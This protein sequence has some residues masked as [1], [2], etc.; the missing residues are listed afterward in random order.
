[1]IGTICLFAMLNCK[2]AVTQRS[3][4]AL[5]SETTKVSLCGLVSETEWKSMKT[6]LKSV[7]SES[8]EICYY[9]DV[10]NTGPHPLTE[11]QSM[12]CFTTS[13]WFALLRCGWPVCFSGEK[14][15]TSTAGTS[16]AD[17]PPPVHTDPKK[18]PFPVFCQA[19]QAQKKLLCLQSQAH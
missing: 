11:L 3:K 14:E 4:S 9:S 5:H 10:C 13:H 15:L 12:R 6:W 18:K 17:H 8:M 16:E 2:L 1:M 19:W 7:L